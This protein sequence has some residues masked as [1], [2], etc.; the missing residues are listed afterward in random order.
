MNL[1][2]LASLLIISTDIAKAYLL[3]KFKS[4]SE[5]SISKLKASYLDELSLVNGG[6]KKCLVA[7]TT[8]RSREYLL[9]FLTVN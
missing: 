9:F 4:H 5:H 7:L 2:F 3:S 1:L 6:S 8:V